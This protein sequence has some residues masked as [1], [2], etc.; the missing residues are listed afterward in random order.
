MPTREQVQ[1]ARAAL[2]W[3]AD[4]LAEKAGVNVD[5]IRQYENGAEAIGGTLMK[6]R[7]AFEAAGVEFTAD[8]GNPGVRLRGIVTSTK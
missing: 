6:M 5:T 2:N 1:M 7:R 4:R 8:G 3:S